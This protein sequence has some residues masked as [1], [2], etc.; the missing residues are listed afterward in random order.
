VTS[1]S[2][3]GAR[4]ARFDRIADTLEAHV[5]LGRLFG[6]MGIRTGAEPMPSRR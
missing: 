4:A 2:F 3:A 1:V 5:D 6:L